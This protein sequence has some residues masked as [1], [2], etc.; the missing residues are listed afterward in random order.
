MIVR[1]LGVALAVFIGVVWAINASV[2]APKP[3]GAL[4][5][6]AHRGVHQTYHRDDLDAQTCTASRIDPP[7]H[8]FLENTL[9][10]MAAAFD[11][12][13]DVVEIDVHL[14]TDGRFAVFHDWTLDCRTEGAGRTRDR[15]LAELKRLDIGYGYSADGG[16]TFPFRGLGVGLM[17][18]L[19]EVFDAFPN[20]RFLINFKSNDPAEGAALV[21]LVEAAPERRSQ[22]WGVYG[23]ARPTEVVREAIPGMRGFTKPSMKAC[24]LAYLKTGW[25]GLIPNSCRGTVIA[26]PLSYTRLV[27]G[28]PDRFLDRMEAAGATVILAGRMEDALGLPAIDDVETLAE[29]PPGFNG[30]V[31]TNRVEIIGPAARSQ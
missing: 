6:I 20:G 21:A 31:W 9:P 5:I 10:S 18:S 24:A 13:A 1:V 25:T 22:I 30:Y 29:A 19:T 15:T 12:G 16:E 8:G 4:K 27:W 3:P 7:T 17:P 28:W 26:V 11:A 2:F 23:G 14:T